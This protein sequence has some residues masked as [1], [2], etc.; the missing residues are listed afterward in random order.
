MKVK[1]IKY[2]DSYY[3]LIP[4]ALGEYFNITNGDLYDL[5]ISKDTLTYKLIERQ[6]KL[7]DF[8]ELKGG[9]KNE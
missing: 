1:V 6:T 4:K 8:K 3:L 9:N 2:G 5:K 7:S